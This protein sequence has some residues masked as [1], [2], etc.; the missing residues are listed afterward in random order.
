M[1][2]PTVDDQAAYLLE[3]V[4]TMKEMPQGK[5]FVDPL[6]RRGY[7]QYYLVIKHPMTLQE[8]EDKILR[9][10][11]ENA[12]ECIDDFRLIFSNAKYYYA[13]Y[14]ETHK[15]ACELENYFDQHRGQLPMYQDPQG[16]TSK[17]KQREKDRVEKEK[18]ASDVEYNGE[19]KKKVSL[20][21]WKARN[22]LRVI[23]APG[24]SRASAASGDAAHMSAEER[25]IQASIDVARE[26]AKEREYGG[27]SAPNPPDHDQKAS[28]QDKRKREKEWEESEAERNWK[29]EKAR[30]NKRRKK[31][32]DR[33]DTVSNFSGKYFEASGAEK[34]RSRLAKYSAEED[35]QEDGEK[36]ST[37]SSF[38]FPGSL[39]KTTKKIFKKLQGKKD[40]KDSPEGYDPA[41][42]S[43]SLEEIQEAKRK[44]SERRRLPSTLT[45]SS[46]VGTL[47]KGG[48]AK[49]KGEKYK[50]DEVSVFFAYNRKQKFVSSHR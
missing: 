22:A 47:R 6:C 49:P 34:S 39:S 20:E 25:A 27:A 45:R 40:D 4:R 33:D 43:M 32:E 26:R 18:K 48:Y 10:L 15:K 12:Q 38:L 44:I 9:G 7:A 42:S 30:E 8:I 3:L 1:R 28:R 41:S 29:S 31:D 13:Y 46:K 2:K 24:S 5:P 14:A 50:R 37:S 19:K 21:Q 16:D 35:A 11:Y 23:D 36:P 17:R